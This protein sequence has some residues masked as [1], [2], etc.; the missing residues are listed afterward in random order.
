MKDQK[1]DSDSVSTQNSTPTK[2]TKPEPETSFDCM[3]HYRQRTF[4][5]F[6]KFSWATPL[7]KVSVRLG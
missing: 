2:E 1:I 5:D 3:S 6:W 7:V 4:W